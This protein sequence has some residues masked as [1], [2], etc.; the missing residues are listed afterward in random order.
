MNNFSK[1]L[2][3]KK[4][5][6]KEE[7][8]RCVLIGLSSDPKAPANIMDAEFGEVVEFNKEIMVCSCRVHVDY[9]GS[10]GYDRKEEYIEIEKKYDSD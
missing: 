5:L 4:E 9:S 1:V 3:V 8:L 6:T 10:V 7:F 2:M